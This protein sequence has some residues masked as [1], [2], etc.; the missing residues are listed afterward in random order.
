M[1]YLEKAKDMYFQYECNLYYMKQDDVMDV[2]LSYGISCEVRDQWRKEYTENLFKNLYKN[3]YK[4][5]FPKLC[6]IARNE[7]VEAGI[8]L[9]LKLYTYY[10]QYSRSHI[11]DTTIEVVKS[12]LYLSRELI[13]LYRVK[14]KFIEKDISLTIFNCVKN[15]INE[16]RKLYTSYIKLFKKEEV[17]SIISYCDRIDKQLEYVSRN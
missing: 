9:F 5:N 13:E 10:Y 14:R 16:I 11:N 1:G 17:E 4:E 12:I 7:S 2:F 8:K 6:Q 15:N 3:S